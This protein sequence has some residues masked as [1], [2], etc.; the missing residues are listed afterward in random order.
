MIDIES[1]LRL[2]PVPATFLGAQF[3]VARPTLLDLTT[4]VELNTTST[5]CARR[6]CLARHLRYLDGTPVFVDADA[7]DG[8]PAALAQVAIPFIEG[9]YSEGSD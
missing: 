4:A 9:L 1:I 8:C 3:L 6:W 2:R 7:A 5:A